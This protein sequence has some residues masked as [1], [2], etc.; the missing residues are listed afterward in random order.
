MKKQTNSSYNQ[1]IINDALKGCIGKL[2]PKEQLKNPIIF[3]V[4]L[5]RFITGF[6]WLYESSH[7]SIPLF[8]FEFWV[9]AWLFFTVLFANFAEAIAE[10][11][12]N[13]ARFSCKYHAWT[14][15]LDGRL[16]GVPDS[17]S[18]PTLDKAKASL[19]PVGLEQWHGF[20]FVRLTDD[21]GPTVA[22]MMAPPSRSEMLEKR[23][24]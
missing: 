14:Y 9:F 2:T 21:G 24:R 15:D 13:A 10:G 19:V 20:W 3:V 4:Y 12:G 17:A 6:I 11:R 22:A 23:I 8:G 16:T 18:Y 5:G 1:A 7:G